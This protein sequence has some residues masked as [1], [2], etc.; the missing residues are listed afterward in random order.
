MK[1]SPIWVSTTIKRADQPEWQA[2]ASQLAINIYIL[3]RSSAK[4]NM[5][6]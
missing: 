1:V 4:P 3:A 6:G 5:S 2:V